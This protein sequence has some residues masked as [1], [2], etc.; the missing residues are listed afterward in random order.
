MRPINCALG[1]VVQWS[2]VD[3]RAEAI[4]Q[5]A[6]VA[7]VLHQRENNGAREEHER[8]RVPDRTEQPEAPDAGSLRSVD[9]DHE[10][11]DGRF[12]DVGQDK[13]G[14]REAALGQLDQV[15]EQIQ[16]RERHRGDANERNDVGG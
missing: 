6:P 12:R 4:R 15:R 9:P 8:V 10:Q 2:E 14:G 16:R 11:R 13:L 5:R 3:P 7:R 1:I